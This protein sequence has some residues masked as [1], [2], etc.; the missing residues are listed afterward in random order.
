MARVPFLDLRVLDPEERQDILDAVAR[1]LDHG[2]ILLGPEVEEFEQVVAAHVGR[3]HAVGCNSGTDALIVALK[4]LRIGPGDEVIVPALSFVATANAVS[5]TGAKPVFADIDDDLNLSVASAASL[6]T[7][8]TKAIVPVHWT[9]L[10]C[11]MDALCDLAREAGL[12]IVEDSSQA[13]DA[14]IGSRKAGSFG[15]IGCFSMNSMKVFASLGE[16]GMLVTADPDLYQRSVTLRYH[17]LV[18]REYCIELAQNSRLD[19]IQAAALLVRF[20][21]LDAVINAR[22]RNAEALNNRLSNHV[23][24]PREP[25]GQRHVFYT[26]TIQ[27]DRRDTLQSYLTSQEIETKVQHPLLMSQHPLYKEHAR[28]SWVNADRLKDRVLC[29]PSNEKITAN[30]LDLVAD[31]VVRFFNS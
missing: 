21:K 27:T 30:Q 19:T 16:A 6:I 13:F 8:A 25:S 7:K 4:A 9:G 31:A 10:L 29:L 11:K 14:A 24:V 5:V 20:K 2:R 28:G 22:R 15:T 3:A 12:H 1:V 17:G 23:V 26:Y 18:N